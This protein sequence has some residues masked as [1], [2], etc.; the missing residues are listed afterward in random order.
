MR[1]LPLDVAVVT[2]ISRAN[3]DL[4]EDKQLQ[5]SYEGFVPKLIAAKNL[6]FM[7]DSAK[8]ELVNKITTSCTRVYGASLGY[9]GAPFKTYLFMEARSFFYFIYVAYRHFVFRIP[10]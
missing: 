1:A 3:K 10:Y 4:E 6:L 2:F 7:E 9:V 5:A 8:E